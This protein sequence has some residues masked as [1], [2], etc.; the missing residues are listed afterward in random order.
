MKEILAP[1]QSRGLLFKRFEPFL[2]KEIGSRKRLEVYHGV[3][4]QNRYTLVIRLKRKSRVL[5]KDVREWFDLKQRIEQHLGYP[6][7]QNIALIEAPLCSKAK[8]LL[9]SE[10]WRVVTA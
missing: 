2:L 8:A 5:Q 4:T 7:L 6:I 1:L 3:D 9:E 10:G